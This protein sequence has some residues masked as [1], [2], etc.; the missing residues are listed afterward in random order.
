M[1]YV[2]ASLRVNRLLP[3]EFFNATVKGPTISDE[4]SFCVANYTRANRRNNSQIDWGL[5]M[6][7]WRRRG[8][9]TLYIFS[10]SVLLKIKFW[11]LFIEINLCNF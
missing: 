9:N 3:N 2:T 5:G 8:R 6:G 1:K 4:I 7:E 11:E 10:L